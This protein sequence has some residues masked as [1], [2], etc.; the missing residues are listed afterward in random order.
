MMT[1]PAAA[2]RLDHTHFFGLHPFLLSNLFADSRG[3]E[4]TANES[5]TMAPASKTGSSLNVAAAEF[6]PG[7][8][9]LSTM[10]SSSSAGQNETSV[11][12]SSNA[13]SLQQGLQHNG[14]SQYTSGQGQSQQNQGQSNNS[15][16]ASTFDKLVSTIAGVHNSRVNTANRQLSQAVSY[17]QGYKQ[18]SSTNGVIKSRVSKPSN[19]S[20]T[21]H[22][23]PQ[24]QRG[25]G[26][27]QSNNR[28]NSSDS[29]GL[30]TGK[31]LEIPA[32]GKR[33]DKAKGQK[34]ITSRKQSQKNRSQQNG[35]NSNEKE[36]QT[37]NS[38]SGNGEAGYQSEQQT[39]MDVD[40]LQS[41]L[42]NL[43]KTPET[44]QKR[45]LDIVQQSQLQKMQQVN[46]ELR[47]VKANQNKQEAVVMRVET[48]S[49]AT[50]KRS[51][52][53]TRRGTR[54]GRRVK[55]NP[56]SQNL[57]DASQETVATQKLSPVSKVELESYQKRVDELEKEKADAEELVEQ[58][59]KQMHQMMLDKQ[60]MQLDFA[61]LEREH[62]NTLEQLF[63]L[64]NLLYTMD[65]QNHEREEMLHEMFNIQS[66]IDEILVKR[67]N[68]LPQSISVTNLVDAG[69]EQANMNVTSSS[70][71]SY[72][73][74]YG[75]EGEDEDED[76]DDDDDGDMAYI[77]QPKSF[78]PT[79]EIEPQSF[80][81]FEGDHLNQG[82]SDIIEEGT[83]EGMDEY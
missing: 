75:E 72:E 19:G 6:T 79:K 77:T 64:E 51:S 27:N 5:N 71:A 26:N 7:K 21:Q 39:S 83:C 13:S 20:S 49:N 25:K 31:V 22:R 4:V 36:N 8:T 15:D 1:I 24:Q 2:Q 30:E 42:S 81:D 66:C 65:S 12:A 14:T 53:K 52:G 3:V 10:R 76:E 33:G 40:M 62:N 29:N 69:R 70:M 80:S 82:I 48:D 60:N 32:H 37:T 38:D 44:A 74:D 59:M 57:G 16:K 41:V 61:A 47:N 45:P 67:H 46:A 68:I 43:D 73:Y 58:V 78:D 11:D 63:Y 9:S 23:Q 56:S 50:T 34:G 28:D 54:A 35:Q 18:Y 55:K 17:A